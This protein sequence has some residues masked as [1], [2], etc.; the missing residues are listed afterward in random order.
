[1]PPYR[2]KRR[3]STRRK[4]P[5]RSSTSRRRRRSRT[6]ARRLYRG[7]DP[8]TTPEPQ[9]TASAH[10]VQG[11]YANCK[12]YATLVDI[13]AVREHIE[14]ENMKMELFV[15]YL[16]WQDQLYKLMQSNEATLD[17]V[18]VFV[19][20][21]GTHV[22]H[23]RQEYIGDRNS[24]L[25]V[26]VTSD[27]SLFVIKSK[28][29]E[30]PYMLLN[31]NMIDLAVIQEKMSRLKK[32]GV[33]VKVEGETYGLGEDQHITLENFVPGDPTDYIQEKIEEALAPACKSG[34]YTHVNTTLSWNLTPK[35]LGQ[36]C[37]R[38]EVREIIRR[39]IV[40]LK[41]L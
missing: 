39:L 7:E 40:E 10:H 29:S 8:P 25:E 17:T 23:M 22:L 36:E 31:T 13:L 24:T 14:T 11:S 21:N 30:T 16:Q 35:S 20:Q 34:T 28:K 41:Q 2:R 9:Q 19:T 12:P 4:Q 1:M 32:P 5:R 27:T 3:S 6:N 33:T 37:S 18:E 26:M 15:S 38:S